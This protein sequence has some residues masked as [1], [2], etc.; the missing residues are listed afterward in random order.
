MMMNHEVHACTDVTGFGLAGHLQ[1]M[2]AD[3]N[4]E[5]II[6]SAELPV[7][8]GA[9]E[10]AA[11]GMIPGGMYKNRDYTGAR[12]RIE[13]SVGKELADIVFDPQ[14][15]GGLLIAVPA[16]EGGVLVA[17]LRS[18]GVKDAAVIAEVKKSTEPLVRVV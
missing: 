9:I 18:A 15:S 7:L 6:R 4:F 2:I 8:P 3:D 16:K 17:G 1:E 11:H 12:W 10:N 13:H 14:T 5:V